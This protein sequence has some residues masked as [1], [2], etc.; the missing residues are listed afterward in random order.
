LV[1]GE[2]LEGRVVGED[3]EE[4]RRMGEGGGKVVVTATVSVTTARK[5]SDEGSLV[6][7]EGRKMR[8]ML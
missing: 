4:G 3:A 8:E 5:D 2:S 1:E 7:S 6:S